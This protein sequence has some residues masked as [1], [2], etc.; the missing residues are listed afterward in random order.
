MVNQQPGTASPRLALRI[1]L[2][3]LA[4]LLTT[5]FVGREV[6]GRLI[7]PAPPLNFDEAAHSLPGYYILRDVLRLDAR[8]FWGDTH[9]QTLWPPGFSYLQA[10]V[11]LLLGL[12]DDAAR[13]FS[14]I[15]LSLA[16]LMGIAVIWSIKPEYTPAAGLVSGL[17]ALSA[18][19]WLMLGGLALQETPVALVACVVFWCFLRALRT[20]HTRWFVFTGCMLFFLF[21]TKYNY[22]AFA[23]AS[24]GLVDLGERVRKARAN[25]FA[26][27]LRQLFTAHNVITFIAIYL[28]VLFGLIFWFYGGTDIV[29]ASVKWRDFNFFVTNENSGYAFWSAENLLFYVRA[30]IDWLMPHPLLAL[31]AMLGA[32]WAVARIRHPGVTLLALFFTIGFVLATVHPLKSDRYVTPVFPSLWALTGL[33]AAD[34]LTLAGNRLSGRLAATCA[35][36][37]VIRSQTLF[38]CAFVVIL[39]AG[40]AASWLTWFPRQQPIWRGDV[41]DS[42]RAASRQIVDWQ[43]PDRPVLIIGTFGELSPPLFEW[44]LRTQPGFANGNIQYDAPPGDGSQIERVQHWLV[45]NPGTQVTL[46]QLDKQAALYNTGD[47]QSKNS[48]RQSLVEQFNQV[49]GYKLVKSTPY[50]GA[51]LLIS[52]YLPQ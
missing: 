27:F 50:P 16:M 44:R 9:I 29:P 30:T 25:Q 1:T 11:L 8:A 23:L 20:Q 14:F 10:P 45:A 34:L 26:M 37:W 28:P 12:S 6:Y 21:L 42:L 3:I 4:L 41:A 22:A 51:G 33:G 32:I 24:I 40:A 49:Q 43:A 46:I 48:W 39:F 5:V 47:M 2:V 38:A 7:L 18:P 19:G 35:K 36:R 31:V 17:I 13:F 15:T 52:Y